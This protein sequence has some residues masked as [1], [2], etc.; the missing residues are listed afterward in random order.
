[1]AR[2]QMT[3]QQL[4]DFLST[5]NSRLQRGL[6]TFDEKFKAMDYSVQAKAGQMPDDIKAQSS[7]TKN[8]FS[9]MFILPSL[10][11]INQQLS[12]EVSMRTPQP[13]IRGNTMRGEVVRNEFEEQLKQFL[14]FHNF[15]YKSKIGYNFGFDKGTIVQRTR[16][17]NIKETYAPLDNGDE[18]PPLIVGGT[19][20]FDYYDPQGTIIDPE[21]SPFDIAHTAAWGIVTLGF[22]TKEAIERTFRVSLDDLRNKNAASFSSAGAYT[23]NE[24]DSR[25]VA[26][27][28]LAGKDDST[29]ERIAV[30]LYNIRTTG[31]IYTIA[32]DGV[33][34]DEDIVDTGALNTLAFNVCPPRP[35]P[36][37]PY[38]ITNWEIIK[39]VVAMASRAINQ[40]LDNN[41]LNNGF[42]L[43]ALAGTTALTSQIGSGDNMYSVLELNDPTGG[44]IQ[45]VRQLIQKIQFPEVSNGASF[46]LNFANQ[47]ISLLTG[48]TTASMGVQAKQMRTEAE[49]GIYQQAIITNSSE[50]VLS[51]ENSHINPVIWDILR[52]FR[53]H[54]DSFNFKEVTR[55]DLYNIKNIHV[56]NGSTLAIDKISRQEMLNVIV[57]RAAMN[58]KVYNHVEIE[59]M[60]NEA[61]GAPKER[62]LNMEVLEGKG[63]MMNRDMILEKVAMQRADQAGG[64]NG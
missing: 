37:S 7:D 22:F 23:G 50:L 36:L 21:A 28:V 46:L 24:N 58:P 57:T 2:S 29:E 47:L 14:S 17:R 44:E 56:V 64:G 52:I 1:M 8:E 26:Q 12:K 35:D 9:N 39:H 31:R 43:V 13:E 45:D 54:F 63:D 59:K 20:D 48:V 40:I 34:V 49:A 61:Y 27:E 25:I 53:R 19:V 30:R 32:G 51:I 55:E 60:I 42:P 5:Y 62:V 16:F 10:T 3:E 33:I 38:G 11:I 4:S 41:D 15:G 18:Q 6:S